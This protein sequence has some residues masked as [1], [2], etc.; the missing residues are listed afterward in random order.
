M[1]PSLRPRR[2]TNEI[3]NQPRVTNF[4]LNLIL[5]GSIYTALK[6]DSNLSETAKKEMRGAAD[7]AG[8]D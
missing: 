3:E 5:T 6:M 4:N 2:E 1:S 7:G 8:P